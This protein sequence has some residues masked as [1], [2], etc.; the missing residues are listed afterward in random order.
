V[1]ERIAMGA[2]EIRPNLARQRSGAR[3]GCGPCRTARRGL[4]ALLLCGALLCALVAWAPARALAA[5]ASAARKD[6]NAGHFTSEELEPLLKALEQLGFS[7]EAMANVFY[8]TRLRKL[9]HVVAINA[10]NPDSSGI[11]EQFTSPYAIHLAR[12]FLRR[13]RQQLQAV[14]DKYG[15]AKEYLVAILLV[16]TQFGQAKL[17][18][19]VLEVFTTLAVEA[20]PEAVER[21][22]ERLKASNPEVEKDW[23]AS[24]LSDKAQFA[25]SELVAAL[26][27]FRDNLQRLY[28]VHGSYAGAIGM[29]QFLPSSYLRWAVD[30]NED[31]RIDL[32]DLNDVLPSIA[33]YLYAHGWSEDAD[34]RERWRAVWEYN[35]STHYTRTIFEIAFRL[36]S[37][38]RKHR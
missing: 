13:H 7:R 22:Y 31:G 34:F 37:P 2:S 15:V 33:N 1:P 29:P 35:H 14:E 28:D 10:M 11:Y 8:D 30:G 4:P 5:D 36:Q 20:H 23:L 3:H 16:E 24:R 21:A 9:D 19:R 32:N 12:R 38:P 25:F 6:D 18:Y 27:M 26:S 17:P